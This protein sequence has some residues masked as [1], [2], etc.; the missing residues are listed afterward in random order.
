MGLTLAMT[1]NQYLN[2]EGHMNLGHLV[3][4]VRCKDLPDNDW[5]D[6]RC[7]CAVDSS[8]YYYYYYDHH[9]YYYH[10]IDNIPYQCDINCAGHFNLDA[11]ASRSVACC[12][13]SCTSFKE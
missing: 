11:L 12:S 2:F 10:S 9:H 7:R 3:T 1:L 6:F 13:V 8:S 4:K 5:G